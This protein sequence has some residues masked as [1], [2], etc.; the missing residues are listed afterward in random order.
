VER[1]FLEMVD[2][3]GKRPA[4]FVRKVLHPSIEGY[5]LP[6]GWVSWE[7]AMAD[8]RDCPEPALGIRLSSLL[9]VGVEGHVRVLRIVMALTLSGW[10]ICRV[11]WAA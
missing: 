6:A 7:A 5:V 2:A 9:T 10:R 1:A 3:A 4:S 8:F 11:E